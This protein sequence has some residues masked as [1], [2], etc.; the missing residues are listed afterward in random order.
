MRLKH[1]RFKLKKTQTG[2]YD[3]ITYEIGKAKKRLIKEIELENEAGAS[4]IEWEN[5]TIE[6]LRGAESDYVDQK[7]DQWKE[8]RGRGL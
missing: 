2:A 8:E 1:F 4:A 6:E 3:V 7:I 5:A